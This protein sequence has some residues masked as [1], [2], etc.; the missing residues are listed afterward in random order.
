[1]KYENGDKFE[2]KIQEKAKAKK[3]YEQ[4]KE[5]GQKTAL[6]ETDSSQDDVLLI[7][8]ANI[9]ASESAV[10][11]ITTSQTRVDTSVWHLNNGGLG[12]LGQSGNVFFDPAKPR[13]KKIVSKSVDFC[14]KSSVSSERHVKL[15]KSMM[16]SSMRTVV[17]FQGIWYKI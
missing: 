6:V 11:E 8:L 5:S 14:E 13:T 16:L 4:A 1:M 12:G 15:H 2:A 17:E 10:V 9:P 3:M 7:N